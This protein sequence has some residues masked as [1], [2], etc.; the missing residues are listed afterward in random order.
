[1]RSL[2]APAI[3]V[4]SGEKASP[5]TPDPIVIDDLYLVSG[6]RA[7]QILIAPSSPADASRRSESSLIADPPGIGCQ[8]RAVTPP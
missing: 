8:T 7:F 4:P 6:E 2:V 1:M 3:Y 5:T